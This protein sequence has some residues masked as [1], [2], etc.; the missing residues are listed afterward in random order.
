MRQLDSAWG[1]RR[2]LF[3]AAG[4]AGSRPQ[5]AWLG[6]ALVAVCGWM[7]PRA[8]GAE[9]PKAAPPASQLALDG[10]TFRVEAFEKGKKVFDDR[11]VFKDGTF[12]SEGC[13]KFGFSESP[14]YVR[15][16]GDQIQFLAETVSPTHGTMVWKGAVKK[17]RI[18][19]G[20]RWR[21]ERW[22]WT[23]LRNFD[24]KGTGAR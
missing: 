1:G 5:L 19:G 20:F 6:V 12:F 2:P 14:Y 7:P 11:L 23:V 17:N 9:T 18:D 3:R 10:R 8:I 21:K 22:Y 15:M 16:E 4:A 24:V 13:R